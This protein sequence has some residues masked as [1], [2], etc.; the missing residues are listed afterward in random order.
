MDCIDLLRGLVGDGCYYP[1]NHLGL[2]G[3]IEVG[4][5]RYHGF[6]ELVPDAFEIASSVKAEEKF[7]EISQQKISRTMVVDP[8]EPVSEVHDYDF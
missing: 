2:A 7:A 1:I 3:L 6:D 4:W 5:P 8:A